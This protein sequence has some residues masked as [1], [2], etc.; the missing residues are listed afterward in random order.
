MLGVAIAGLARRVHGRDGR[1]TISS[2]N[3][4]FTYDIW[5]PYIRKDRARRL[6]PAGRPASSR[7]VGISK[8]WPNSRPRSIASGY[9]NVNELPSQTPVQLLSN[10]PLF[11]G[12]SSWR[13]SGSG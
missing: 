7:S 9:G 1:G 6:L 2:F 3:T 11:R 5:Q 10:A 4:V 12:R 8:R 13:C